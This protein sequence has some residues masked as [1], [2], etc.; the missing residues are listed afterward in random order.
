MLSRTV[1]RYS[2]EHDES[3]RHRGH[4]PLDQ[5]FNV[6]NIMELCKNTRNSQRVLDLLSSSKTCCNNRLVS[7]VRR[8]ESSLLRNLESSTSQAVWTRLLCS[9][10]CFIFPDFVCRQSIADMPNFDSQFQHVKWCDCV[11]CGLSLLT[12]L[13]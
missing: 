10:N 2:R 3:G 4:M 1:S 6:S 9:V 7:R 8:A 5:W 13:V 11:S 12:K